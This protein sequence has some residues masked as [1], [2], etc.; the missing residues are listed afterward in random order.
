MLSPVAVPFYSTF[1]WS[2]IKMLL[3]FFPQCFMVE[4]QFT[5]GRGQSQEHP[6]TCN[7]SL[8]EDRVG[9]SHSSRHNPCPA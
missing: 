3:K 5:S 9:L 2:F 8:Q 7:R 6:V 4:Q 1:E